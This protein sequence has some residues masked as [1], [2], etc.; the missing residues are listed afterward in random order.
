M[1]SEPDPSSYRNR[2]LLVDMPSRAREG[3]ASPVIR[4]ILATSASM[5]IGSYPHDTSQNGVCWCLFGRRQ[6]KMKRRSVGLVWPRACIEG[7]HLG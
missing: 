2:I 5:A 4:R 6:T 3:Q 7:H 1:A